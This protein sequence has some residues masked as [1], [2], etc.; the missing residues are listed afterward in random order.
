MNRFTNYWS[1]VIKAQYDKFTDEE[2]TEKEDE[3][4]ID[5]V[6]IKIAQTLAIVAIGWVIFVIA[7]I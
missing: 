2:V 7:V 6:T 4:K 5:E 3:L 1:T